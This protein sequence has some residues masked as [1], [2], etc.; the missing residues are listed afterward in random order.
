M[1]DLS[2]RIYEE[3]CEVPRNN[4]CLLFRFI[5]K[6]AVAAA[7]SI[8]RVSVCPVY[9]NFWE[10]LELGIVASL[11][12]CLYIGFSARFLASELV[13]WECEDLKSLRLVLFVELHHLPIV[14]VCE[15]SVS[16]DVDNHKTLF[17]GEAISQSFN[18]VSI[19]VTCAKFQQ[20]LRRT[21]DRISAA[22]FDGW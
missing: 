22:L 6:R 21:L 17:V 8:Y 5:P 7:E 10:K 14:L 1:H 2:I 3:L 4:L 18:L 19:D 12:K 9:I 16:S 20:T 13:A 11:G 15:A